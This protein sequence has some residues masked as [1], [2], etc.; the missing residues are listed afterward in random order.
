M[1][2]TLNMKR[3]V[4]AVAFAG[5]FAVATAQAQD[6]PQAKSMSE[7]LRLVEQGRVSDN[8]ENQQREREFANAKAEQQNLLNKARGD[9]RAAE[10]RS[11]RLETE[12]DTNE[13]EIAELTATLDQRLGSLKELFGVMQQVAGDSRARFE[14]S[15]TNIQY[16]DRGEFLEGLAKKIGSS[17]Q[18]PSLG[19][20]RAVVVRTA[21]RDDRE[22]SG[23]A[24]Q[25]RRGRP[26]GYPGSRREVVRVGLFNIIDGRQVSEVRAVDRHCVRTAAPAGAGALHLTALRRCSRPPAARPSSASTRPWA[27]C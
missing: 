22:R 19:R 12:Y 25:R 3:A 26:R 8:R 20:D 21:A 2:R 16:P 9:K 27:A 1:M 15:L 11:E 14:G 24:L 4:A 10:Q 18:L 17:S 7:L 6:A 5:L 23:R 13:G